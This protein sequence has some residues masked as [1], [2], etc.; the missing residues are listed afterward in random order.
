[1]K[2]KIIDKIIFSVFVLKKS[3]LNKYLS[4]QLNILFEREINL[5]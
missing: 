1:M 2:K 5:F 4:K 3:K